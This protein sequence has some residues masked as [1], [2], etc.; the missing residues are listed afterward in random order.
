MWNRLTGWNLLSMRANGD[1]NNGKWEF[2]WQV[3]GWPF[4]ALFVA[5]LVIDLV[6]RFT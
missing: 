2:E 5:I 3:K 6:L 1:Y 4:F